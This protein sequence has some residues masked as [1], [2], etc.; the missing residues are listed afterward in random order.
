[1]IYLSIF[2]VCFGKKQ[3]KKKPN[4]LK[5]VVLVFS[6]QHQIKNKKNYTSFQIIRQFEMWFQFSIEVMTFQTIINLLYTQ[7]DK[8]ILKKLRKTF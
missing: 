5:G 2:L 7:N 1:L 8:N 6:K 3:K 4:R